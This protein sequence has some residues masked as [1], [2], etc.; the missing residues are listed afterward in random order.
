MDARWRLALDTAHPTAPEAPV[1]SGKPVTVGARS[2][3][4]LVGARRAG[5]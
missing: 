3:L 1:Q 2:L 5:E 4:L